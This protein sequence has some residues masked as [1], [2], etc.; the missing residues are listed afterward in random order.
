MTNEAEDNLPIE[1]LGPKALRRVRNMPNAPQW[2]TQPT[3]QT[4]IIE[5]I[6]AG[7]TLEEVKEYYR[8]MREIEANEAER[9]AT[10]DFVAMQAELPAIPKIGEIDI[11]KGKPQRY[12]R[13]EDINKKIKPVLSRYHY[14]LNFHFVDESETH[15][16]M[17]AILKHTSGYIDQTTRRLPLDKSGSKNI[18]QAYGST[19]SYAQRYL[20]IAILNLVAEGE[21]DDA[22]AAGAG[23]ILGADELEIIKAALDDAGCDSKDTERF[24]KTMKVTALEQLR[25][26]QV[27]DAMQRIAHFKQGKKDAAKDQ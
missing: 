25:R 10:A 6:R 4:A 22:Q 24:L 20:A 1:Q 26:D 2:L 19:Q 15:I 11:G 12:M 18:V 17:T 14:G 8:F 5:R 27:A 23:N 3:L 7:G 9:A 13:W 21:D 16:T